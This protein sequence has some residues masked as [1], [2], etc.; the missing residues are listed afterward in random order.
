MKANDYKFQV[1]N[2]VNFDPIEK[3]FGIKKHKKLRIIY[4]TTYS[5]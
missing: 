4:F 3:F 2:I 1:A 5:F